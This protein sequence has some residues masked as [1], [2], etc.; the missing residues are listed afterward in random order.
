MRNY[1]QIYYIS[2]AEPLQLSYLAA[3]DEAWLQLS[4]AGA[5][6]G[7]SRNCSLPHLLVNKVSGMCSSVQTVW[8]TIC[9]AVMKLDSGEWWA[10]ET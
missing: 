9:I 8:T 2:R 3:S 5:A 6:N 10:G 4:Y 7:Q 1:Y